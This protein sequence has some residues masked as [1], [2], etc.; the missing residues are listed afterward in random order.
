LGYHVGGVTNLDVMTI[1]GS[2]ISNNVASNGVG[3]GI[4]NNGSSLTLTGSEVRNNRSLDSGLGTGQG[5][6]IG[7]ISGQ[8][9]VVDSTIAGNS[10]DDNG[11][12]CRVEEG[13][14]L[15]LTNVT[16][17]SNTADA[18]SSGA[19]DGGGIY[20][21]DSSIITL[22]HVTVSFNQA[23]VGSG[24]GLHLTGT[25]TATLAN[26]IISSNTALDCGGGSNPTSA[27]YN[28]DSDNTCNLVATGDI[29]NTNPLL[30]P[31]QDNGGP[32]T[33]SGQATWTHALLGGSPAIDVIPPGQC[34]L[35]T[36]QRGITRPQNS[37]C[38]I[39]AYEA[40]MGPSPSGNSIYLPVVLK[41]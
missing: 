2:V 28:L 29:T 6:G 25:V 23:A 36:D 22:T 5:G 41:N 26:T 10:A 1:T 40:N 7:Q 3:S 19:G 34:P 39:G 24:G 31:L 32:A 38:D 17:S 9:N 11:G 12:G 33:S 15:N 30:G 13:S 35:P 4:F 27:G 16:I 14:T 18:D 8:M 20:L 21:E 37:T